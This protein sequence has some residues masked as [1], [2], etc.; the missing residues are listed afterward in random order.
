M[1]EDVFSSPALEAADARTHSCSLSPSFSSR[2]SSRASSISS[3][4]SPS[5]PASREGCPAPAEAPELDV[6]PNEKEGGDGGLAFLLEASPCA[7][8]PSVSVLS[9][10]PH[11]APTGRGRRSAGQGPRARSRRASEDF[12]SP[13]LS[14]SSPSGS[15]HSVP[16]SFSL[17]SSPQQL[18]ENAA[19][20]YRLLQLIEEFYG[21]Q[22]TLES[23][24][25]VASATHLNILHT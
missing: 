17:S 22:Q 19:S 16:S 24:K 21:F 14:S 15:S 25:Q 20:R 12:S 18:F 6:H 13:L 1:D 8:S 3:C 11:N 7:S 2:S 23:L 9:V 10:S 5:R 4:S